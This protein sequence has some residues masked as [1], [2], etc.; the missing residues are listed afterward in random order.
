LR[1]AV[2]LAAGLSLIAIAVTVVLSRPP[3]LAAGVRMTPGRS[4]LTYQKG[5]R[6]ICQGDEVLPQG[7]VA[8]R[9]GLGANVGPRVGFAAFSGGRMLTR[10]ERE[11]GWG[12]DETVTVPV[13]RVTRTARDV[14]VCTTVGPT[15]EPIEIHEA[16][17]PGRAVGAGGQSELK[18]EYLR[19]ASR[20]WLSMVAPITRNMG[21]GH[22]PGGALSVLLLLAL[23]AAVVALV[24]LLV[25]CELGAA[26]RGDK[27]ARRLLRVPAQAWVCA[28][29]AFLSAASWS[30]LT[31]PFQVTD[32]PSHFA[33]VQLLAE[34]GRLP[35]SGESNFSP[36]EEIAL[37]GFHHSEVLWYPEHR[38]ISSPAQ[39]RALERDLDARSSRVDGG[40]AGVARS[41]PPLYYALE[42]LPYFL[43]SGG[44]LLDQLE[45][46]RLLSALLA[47]LTALFAYMFVREALPRLRWSWTVGGLS[48]ALAPL[49][50]LMSGAVNPDAMLYA[51]CACLL[52]LLARGFRRGLTV[53]VALAIGAVAAIGFLTKL[54]FIGLAPGMVLGLLA[55]AF[56]ARR[57]TPGEDARPFLG[58][59]EVCRRLALAFA[60]AFSPVIVYATSNALSRRPTFGFLSRTL[61]TSQPRESL[62][63]EIFY[64]WQLFLPRLPG[65][66]NDFPGI[67]TMR[68]IWFDRG[69]GMYGWLD[70]S[71]PPWVNHL[72]LIL[73][74][75]IV[76]LGLS[77]LWAARSALRGRL[78]E[79][80]V[81]AA[82]AG[83]M[84]ALVG[85][86]SYRHLATEGGG[87]LQP[88]YLLPMLPLLAAALA[89]SA[90]GAG[91]RWGPVA[92][93]LIVLLFLAH[94]IFSQLLTI[95]RFY[96]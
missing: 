78:T 14:R 32:E 70:T 90:R 23:M 40:D 3:L 21:F 36:A 11:A 33:Y 48:A 49:L 22:A 83:G 93:T 55:L 5:G 59:G 94:D 91:R 38:T 15:I 80:A 41:Q 50:G 84:L 43:G 73:A 76:G 47:G 30:L 89:L 67:F 25:I 60:V 26:D 65:M 57:N 42:L 92:G 31:P 1:V 20:S 72:A 12:I 74:V 18:V 16:S 82:M 75:P 34:T 61:S 45:L 54:N 71:F 24:S 58:R 17:V 81:Y 13:R 85:A 9:L 10:G 63:S 8:V 88:R 64:A 79:V 2:A 68:Q 19:P 95:S 96:G 29:V 87:Y 28:L 66:T 52:Y 77:A 86:D 4:L 62:L 69:V 39:Q 37:R 46:M 53:G 51:V 7:T 44:T 56:R 35:T 6:S 27:A